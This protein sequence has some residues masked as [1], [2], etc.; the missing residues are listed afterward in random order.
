MGRVGVRQKIQ[1]LVSGGGGGTVI[2][3]WRVIVC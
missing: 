1:K 3:D 2:W